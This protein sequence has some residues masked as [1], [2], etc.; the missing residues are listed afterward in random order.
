MKDN[1]T[2]VKTGPYSKIRHPMCSS[3]ALLHLGLFLISCNLLIGIV[4]LAYMA[5]IISRI[6]K[7]ALEFPLR[8]F[9]APKESSNPDVN[10]ENLFPSYNLTYFRY[11]IR[12]S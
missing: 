1:H 7:D 11:V 12:A 3:F 6:P 8:L 2:L 4:G 9:F 5:V 10:P